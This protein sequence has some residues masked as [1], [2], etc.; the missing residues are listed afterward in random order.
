MTPEQQ[1]LVNPPTAPIACPTCRAVAGAR[2]MSGTGHVTAQPHRAR[3]RAVVA[4]LAAQAAGTVPV[5]DLAAYRARR[6]RRA[7]E[8]AQFGISTPVT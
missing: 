2:C 8:R 7:R 3:Q 1:A 5:G 6:R 4:F